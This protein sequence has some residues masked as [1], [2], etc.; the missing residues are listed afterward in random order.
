MRKKIFHTSICL[1]FLTFYTQAQER[2]TKDFSGI[3]KISIN[4]SSG[5]C[6]LKKGNGSEVKVELVH[7]F[8]NGYE[9]V[10]E[11]EGSKLII[12]EEF[13]RG[14]WN[15]SAKWTLTIPDNMD[16][17]FNT[18][19]GD[20]EA[21]NLK[22]ELDM[23]TGSGDIILSSIKGD[24]RSNTGSGDVEVSDFDGELKAN[25]GSGN[26]RLA[27]AV[28]EVKLNCGSGNIRIKDT[29][30]AISANVGS[31]DIDASGLTLAGS[32]SFNSGSGTTE[33]ALA[34]SPKFDISVN[35]GSGD[36]ILDFEGNK[37]E[38]L[39]VMRANKKNGRISA[40][41]AFD[42]EEE[43]QQGSGRWDQTVIKKT[44]QIGSSNVE[45]KVGSGSG[46]A[47]ISK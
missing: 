2:I 46:T 16:I 20:F 5:D 23:N 35:S 39:V 40:P 27:N 44:A 8:G 38:G 19:S 42:K 30:A 31:G 17:R 47:K 18:G 34:A 9:P 11:K 22:F 21:S 25:T 36:A 45:I 13:K 26:M 33:V 15:G 28:G 6:I 29:N 3:E 10:I 1:L 14:S 24:L 43:E 4:T 7:D 32:S 41:F 37:I 12:K